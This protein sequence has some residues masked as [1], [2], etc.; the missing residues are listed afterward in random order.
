MMKEIIMKKFMAMF[1]IMIMVVMAM[2]IGPVKAL[3]AEDVA[4]E[5]TA[6]SAF[7]EVN[8]KFAVID[9]MLQTYMDDNGMEIR[10]NLHTYNP[11]TGDVVWNLAYIDV[12]GQFQNEVE[13]L[14]IEDL[15]EIIL[16]LGYCNAVAHVRATFA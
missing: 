8:N 10:W 9:P 12:A 16:A 3:A 4:T 11:F 6:T 14:E 1:S 2:A 7:E 13:T 15:D 5:A